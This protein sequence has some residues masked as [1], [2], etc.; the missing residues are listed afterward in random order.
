MSEIG[1]FQQL[2]LLSTIDINFRFARY[3]EW[4]TRL[5]S[6]EMD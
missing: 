3:P 4:C 5:V 1:I 6:K 2:R